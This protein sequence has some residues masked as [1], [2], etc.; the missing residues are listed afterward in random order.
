MQFY[1][2]MRRN[3]ALHAVMLPTTPIEARH[4]AQS[5]ITRWL[6]AGRRLLSVAA[7]FP[8]EETVRAHEAVERGGKRGTVVVE[9]AS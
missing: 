6:A 8:L 4:R 9:I 1:D 5:D 2:L 7:R 3:L